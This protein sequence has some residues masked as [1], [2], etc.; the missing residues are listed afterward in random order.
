MG[1][2]KQKAQ[3]YAASL[4]KLQSLDLNKISLAIQKLCT[5]A[6]ANYGRDCYLHT[7]LCQALLAELDVETE[8]CVGFA[9]W[10][11]GEGDADVILHA[12]IATCRPSEFA[13]WVPNPVY[14]KNQEV[15]YHAWLL[16]GQTI[17]DFTTYQLPFKGRELDL[18]DGG[19]TQVDW[20]PDFLVTPIAAASTFTE[21]QRDHAGLF[22]YQRHPAL[23]QLMRN[24]KD[25]S[26]DPEDFEMLK[27]IYS[28]TDMHVIG[29]NHI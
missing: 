14:A 1:Q 4:E 21:V 24:T 5:A 17:I 28:N 25:E 11:V 16:C 15:P 26:F 29:P 6:S 12:P 9:G 18:Q 2:A 13:T 23:E 7:Q 22:W 3:R 27:M 10:R 19:K 8:L 20:C